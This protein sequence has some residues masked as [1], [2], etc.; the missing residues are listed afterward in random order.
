MLIGYV[1]ASF[2]KEEVDLFL[3]L[4][5]SNVFQ[6]SAC[7]SLPHAR[8]IWII[9]P[10]AN[11]LTGLTSSVFPVYKM[12]CSDRKNPFAP[13]K[14]SIPLSVRDSI[15]FSIKCGPGFTD[16]CTYSHLTI[17]VIFCDV[18]LLIALSFL[19]TLM[20]SDA[21]TLREGNRPKQS[22]ASKA[23]DDVLNLIPPSDRFLRK[24]GVHSSRF[25]GHA[26]TGP[27][28]PINFTFEA[29]R[30]VAVSEASVNSGLAA[31]LEALARSSDELLFEHPSRDLCPLPWDVSSI[32]NERL[33]NKNL[34]PYCMLM[35]MSALRGVVNKR[36]HVLSILDLFELSCVAHEPA[37]ELTKE[38][39]SCLRMALGIV[40]YPLLSITQD[41]L[42]GVPVLR[43]IRVLRFVSEDIMEL[44]TVNSSS[45]A[46]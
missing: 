9:F 38:D 45:C 3:A 11:Y 15:C 20:E 23:K 2:L 26:L 34:S 8:G 17:F 41:P 40:G 44:H 13:L 12:C 32:F 37:L 7:D 35:H 27:V 43:N 1:M 21:D 31:F 5:V 22:R 28:K 24:G 36:K 6:L 10:I 42:T 4:L 16:A 46:F 19:P 33:L 39:R 29:G 18:F 30:I 14:K 25:T